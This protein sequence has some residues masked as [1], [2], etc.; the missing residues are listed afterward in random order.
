MK[1]STCRF[2]CPLLFALSFAYA[3]AAQQDLTD[4]S[5]PVRVEMPFRLGSGYLIVVEGRVG[6]LTGLKFILD[7]GTSTSLLDTHVAS[8]LRLKRRAS[9]LINFGKTVPVESSTIPNVQ[10]GPVQATNVEMY[11]GDLGKFSDF[12]NGIDAIIGLDLLQQNN[13]TFDYKTHKVV[14]EL[15]NHTNRG[16]AARSE[17]GCI[18]VDLR[19]QDHPL[20]L[21]LDTGL[22]GIFLFEGRVQ[23]KVPGLRMAN[24]IERVTIGRRISAKEATLPEMRLGP[25]N[26]NGHVLL[27]K[28]P[29]ENKLDGIDGFLGVTSFRAERISLNFVTKRIS[30]VPMFSN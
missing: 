11:I 23:A 10:F 19:V 15:I 6:D 9:S 17:T 29:A 5:A 27:L 12:A 28:D 14:F 24:V 1:T 3:I 21:I 20:H 22:D 18:T 13:L 16:T 2:L 30:W 4:N 26:V 8:M 25:I 7:T